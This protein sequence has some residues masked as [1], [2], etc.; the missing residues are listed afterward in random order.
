MGERNSNTRGVSTG[1][2]TFTFPQGLT[3]IPVNLAVSYE[4]GKIMLTAAGLLES[5][6]SFLGLI[7]KRD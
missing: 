4:N 5:F 7:F 2:S 6:L 3:L 1:K